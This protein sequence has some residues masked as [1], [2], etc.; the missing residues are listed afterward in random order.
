MLPHRRRENR[1]G[2]WPDRCCRRCLRMYSC[3][4]T[5]RY[6][7]MYNRKC[8]RMCCRKFRRMSRN[9]YCRSYQSMSAPYPTGRC[10]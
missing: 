3:K 9:R 7:R 6:C 5:R 2:S 8:H 4:L 1:S 10:P